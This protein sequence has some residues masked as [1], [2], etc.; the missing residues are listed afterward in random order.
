MDTHTRKLILFLFFLS[1]ACGLIYEVLWVRMLGLIFGNTTYAVSTV[2]AAYMAGLA[3]GSWY[4]GHLIDRT[5]NSELRTYG[6]LMLGIGVYC[7]FTPLIFKLV[8]FLYLNVA[9][10]SLVFCFTLSFIAILIPAALMGG[11]LPVLTK[12]FTNIEQRTTGNDRIGSN[13]G[14]LYSIN[15]WGGVLGSFLTGYLLIMILGVKGALYLASAINL[16]VAGV[17]FILFR[18]IPQ[19]FPLLKGEREEL[20][21]AAATDYIHL[22]KQRGG[23]G[24]PITGNLILIAIALS[25][26]TALVYE[27]VWTRVLSLVLGSSV[28]AFTIMLCAF[29]AGIAI[30]SLIYAKFGESKS[31]QY[32]AQ[33]GF[34]QAGIGVSVLLLIPI[35][36]ILPFVFLKI[37]KAFG[38]NFGGFQFFQFLLAFGVM[39]LP[40]ILFGITIPFA[41]KIYSG[42]KSEINPE[43]KTDYRSAGSSVGNVYA[44]NT[45]GA[46]IG[47]I[48]AGFCLIPLIGLQKTI[49]IAAM[50]NIGLAIILLNIGIKEK[51]WARGLVI[52]FLLFFT[53]PY[54][55]A[56][57]V[58]NKNVLAGGVYQY[59]PDFFS[60]PYVPGESLVKQW[61]Q[62]TEARTK[63]LYYKEGVNFTVSVEKN[64]YSK[65]IILRIDGK[66][67]ATNNVYRDM[68]SQKLIAHLPLLIYRT[69]K[70]PENVMLVGLASGMTLGSVTLHPVKEIDCVEIEPAMVEAS[71]YFDEF[72]YKPLEDKRV[73][74]IINDAR[75]YLLT[76]DKKYDIIISEPSNPWMSGQSN[77][78]TEEFFQL[79]KK[80]LTEDGIFCAW[81]QFYRITPEM[82]KTVL[83][84]FQ[85]VFPH[86]S[87]WSAS[88]G[89]TL[90]IATNKELK[91]DYQR[92]V[93]LMKNERIKNDLAQVHILSP[94]TFMARRVLCEDKARELTSDAKLH[95]DNFPRLE[96]GAGKSLYRTE[97][98]G[99]IKN[100][101]KENIETVSPML[102]NFSDY[103]K[104]IQI[105]LSKRLYSA[106]LSELELNSYKIKPA[107]RANLYG[108]AYMGLGDINKA[109][110]E[111]KKA[112]EIAPEFYSAWVNLS[113]IY[114][115][116]GNY[117]QAEKIVNFLLKRNAALAHSEKGYLYLAQN[118]PEDAIK[119]FEKAISLSPQDIDNYLLLGRIYT[120]YLK[121]PP[122]AIIVLDKAKKL[123]PESLEV[124]YLLGKAYLMMGSKRKA[125][126]MFNNCITVDKGYYKKI[127]ELVKNDAE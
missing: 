66:A 109:E 39:L 105:Y 103:E 92:L 107:L 23:Q 30:G 5:T 76:A 87:V 55:I 73:N 25:G 36:G 122:G 69:R 3:L 67:D 34:I 1:G 53:I 70:N 104:L 102:R 59:A 72:N 90:L 18:Q 44:A 97:L 21:V 89:D 19:H 123:F 15:T 38:Q 96:Y 35:F 22:S 124:Y 11:T 98:G 117:K 82:Y 78:F 115:E 45:I 86:I 27:V 26:F 71:H 8:Q 56:V 51:K 116:K 52:C 125:E 14:I 41:C 74:L 83:R 33:F 4:F 110:E 112:V 29:L 65:N 40:T 80:H 118:K 99:R 31:S 81:L 64:T 46:I 85:S 43:Q 60:G 47:S 77:L 61:R 119:E 62:W 24:L 48:L 91:I 16:A 58:W 6:F 12:Y 95:T 10:Q 84:T 94:L 126:E 120:D 32:I 63:D 17:V 127:A 88:Y 79:A 20:K 108:R 113:R 101:L 28:Y 54:V 7:I 13:V 111:F 114:R 93:E 49:T 50:I 100:M 68:V 106:A 2:L 42:E 57:P 121:I 37:F 9:P 75:N